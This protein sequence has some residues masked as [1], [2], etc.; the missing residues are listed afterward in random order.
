M[1]ERFERAAQ[2]GTSV[3]IEDRWMQ[4]ANDMN[5]DA[6]T[7]GALVSMDK[8]ILTHSRVKGAQS[9][10]RHTVDSIYR[11]DDRSLQQ[12]ETLSGTA[13]KL[14]RSRDAEGLRRLVPTINQQVAVD[15][16]A[17]Q[18]QQEVNRYGVGFMKTMSLFLQGDGGAV[19]TGVVYALDQAKP[20]DKVQRQ[21]LD[22]ALGGLKGEAT[23]GMVHALAGS[24][25]SL[26]GKGV[27]MGASS[28]FIDQ[29]LTV[30]NY[31]DRKSGKYSLGRGLNNARLASTNINSLAV[32]AA[33]YAT[34][35]TILNGMDDITNGAL[36]HSHFL[37]TLTTGTTFGLTGGALDEVARQ[38]ANR[39][40]FDFGKVVK[41]SLLSGALD[42]IAALPGAIQSDTAVQESIKNIFKPEAKVVASK[43]GEISYADPEALFERSV[44]EGRRYVFEKNKYYEVQ[45]RQVTAAEGELVVTKENATGELAKPGS[46]VVERQPGDVYPISNESFLQRWRPVDGK[47][48]VFSPRPVPTEMVELTQPLDIKTKWGDMHGESGSFLARY[49]KGNFAIV[50]RK[51]LGETYAGSDAN[52]QAKAVEITSEK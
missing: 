11:T 48:G 13:E 3:E 51:A 17:L 21:I 38:R 20:A 22:G 23:R 2:L 24:D 45:A 42:T 31:Y 37:Q 16:E 36:S 9:Y 26:A 28:R 46:W 7:F 39:E 44:Q 18:T 33:V 40:Q 8:E 34:T 25:L 49:E 41:R 35:G 6:T 4:I 15:R 1:V 32:D 30:D 52:S 47:T 29:S 43:P 12:L 10:A 14:S 19:S 27:I 5:L 50:E